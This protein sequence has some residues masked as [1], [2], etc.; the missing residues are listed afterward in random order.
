MQSKG[1]KLGRVEIGGETPKGR[2]E[3][4]VGPIPLK[5]KNQGSDRM[6]GRE[7]EE[8]G[9]FRGFQRGGG[10]EMLN[11]YDRQIVHNV[12]IYLHVPGLQQL[13]PHTWRGYAVGA[14]L[15]MFIPPTHTH[16]HAQLGLVSLESIR[17]FV[18]YYRLIDPASLLNRKVVSQ[19]CIIIYFN[20]T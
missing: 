14:T 9:Q 15:S 17:G 2:C 6:G 7:G 8:K 16:A 5:C 20:L 10:G 1:G 4:G 11:E 13:S 12:D 3:R 18:Y 19:I